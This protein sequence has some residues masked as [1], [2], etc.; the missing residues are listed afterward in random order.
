MKTIKD[1]EDQLHRIECLWR[2]ECSSARYEAN[3]TRYEKAYDIMSRYRNNMRK[4]IDA[5]YN[6]RKGHPM[7]GERYGRDVEVPRDEYAHTTTQKYTTMKQILNNE[8]KECLKHFK[9]ELPKQ[10]IKVLDIAY[11]EINQSSVWVFYFSGS[12]K[13]LEYYLMDESENQGTYFSEQIGQCNGQD[14]YYATFIIG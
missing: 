2:F 14:I 12:S 8:T 5:D 6:N 9:E 1:I 10:G 11:T 13:T 4:W 7:N 3:H